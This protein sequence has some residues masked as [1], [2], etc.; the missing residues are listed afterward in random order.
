MTRETAAN[1]SSRSAQELLAGNSRP[2]E[3]A[4]T[5]ATL[6]EHSEAPLEAQQPLLS[7]ASIK[8][9]SPS[10]QPCHGSLLEQI[11][12]RERDIAASLTLAPHNRLASWSLGAFSDD[13]PEEVLNAESTHTAASLDASPKSADTISAPAIAKQSPP[14]A[15][16]PHRAQASRR[17]LFEQS[18]QFAL[19]KKA[20][21]Q[22]AWLA[23]LGT[24]DGSPS[25][26]PAKK[27]SG[28]A[29]TGLH[30]K[31][32]LSDATNAGR[33]STVSAH[34]FSTEQLA[35]AARFAKDATRGGHKQKAS[36]G[37][38]ARSGPT[39]AQPASTSPS[40]LNT[41]K[42]SRAI[43][44]VGTGP[45]ANPRS[46]L[47]P[48]TLPPHLQKAKNA[49]ERKSNEQQS[50]PIP[51]VIGNV[52]TIAPRRS[53]Q[54]ESLKVEHEAAPPL[55]RPASRSM[56]TDVLKGLNTA[57]KPT[58]QQPSAQIDR[59]PCNIQCKQC[60]RW[61]SVPTGTIDSH[62]FDLCMP[63]QV[64]NDRIADAQRTV[65]GNDRN[66]A[67]VKLG[68]AHQC[69][70]CS[71]YFFDDPS[72]PSDTLQICSQCSHLD[73]PPFTE[74]GADQ[75]RVSG[76]FVEDDEVP[77][78]QANNAAN[79]RSP[80]G[81]H[82][83]VPCATESATS[84]SDGGEKLHSSADESMAFGNPIRSVHSSLSNIGRD[85][86]RTSDGHGRGPAERADGVP[87]MCADRKVQA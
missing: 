62:Q 49:R 30:G 15:T 21:A 33:Q 40:T 68:T 46:T 7:D 17:T 12:Q 11:A 22:N 69:I 63:C 64:V 85:D 16:P 55:A 6:P 51:G 39:A 37:H 20:V 57:P 74:A 77:A 87:G 84:N 72:K 70:K 25:R 27:R 36:S 23:S 18:A 47:P 41:R 2:T 35:E 13:D 10:D 5:A 75:K 4:S 83:D 59:A 54:H 58:D 60:H 73:R 19:E 45:R 52:A 8:Q 53:E 71:L 1:S 67:G 48:G 50:I 82:T 43:G 81:K 38:N 31:P 44:S 78:D 66:Q 28:Q 65:S 42:V 24:S 32:A 34:G 29:Q 86:L 9:V 26:G 76:T 3:Q 14:S 79:P 56:S 61:F 80:T